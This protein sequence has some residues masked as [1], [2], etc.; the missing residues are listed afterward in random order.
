MC[1]LVLVTSANNLIYT[2]ESHSGLLSVFIPTQTV[3]IKNHIVLQQN[4]T[5]TV[6]N[7]YTTIFNYFGRNA[8]FD[9]I[10]L[11]LIEHVY[12]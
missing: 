8:F 6:G 2:I 4:H 10:I 1:I 7:V 12:T 11:H 5:L 9:R 3:F